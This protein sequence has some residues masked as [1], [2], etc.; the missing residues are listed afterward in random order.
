MV[1]IANVYYQENTFML[2][3]HFIQWNLDNLGSLNILL[4]DFL[5]S[6]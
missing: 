3:L 6:P 2:V 4:I 5:S 1:I